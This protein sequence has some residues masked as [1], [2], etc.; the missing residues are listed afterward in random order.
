MSEQNDKD[1]TGAS[2][3]TR[4]IKRLEYEL[5]MS[6]AQNDNNDKATKAMK[7]KNT[8]LTKLKTKLENQ[9]MRLEQQIKPKVQRALDLGKDV[10]SKL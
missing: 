8:E 3:Q 2:E 7:D 10:N 5:S 6:R 9:V 4:L 1:D